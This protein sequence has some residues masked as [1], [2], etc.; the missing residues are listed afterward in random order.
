MGAAIRHGEPAL[1]NDAYIPL[2]DPT[3]DAAYPYRI[4][5]PLVMTEVANGALVLGRTDVPFTEEEFAR[6]QIIA[7]QR[8]CDHRT[9]Y[10][11][12]EVAGTEHCPDHCK[13]P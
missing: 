2:T 3:T 13:S 11:H 1:V 5:V 12:D 7:E 8:R 10:V 4:I 9:Y 6:A